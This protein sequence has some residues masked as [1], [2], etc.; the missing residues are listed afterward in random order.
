MSELQNLLKLSIWNCP[1][2]SRV[3]CSPA[4]T[5]TDIDYLVLVESLHT[6]EAAALSFGWKLGGSKPADEIFVIDKHCQFA[7]VTFGQYNVIATTSQV[8]YG[9]FMAATGVA[10]RLNLLNKKDRIMLFQ[11]VLYSRGPSNVY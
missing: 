11:A 4:S 8:F 2:G 1:V 5:D 3:T 6:F 7:S 9:R 10:K